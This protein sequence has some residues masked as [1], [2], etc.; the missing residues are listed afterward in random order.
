MTI[1]IQAVWKPSA[2]DMRLWGRPLWWTVGPSGDLA[3]MFVSQRHL[4]QL[5]YIAGWLAWV[6]EAPFDGVLVIRHGGGPVHQRTIKDIPLAP[7]HIA[8]LS[9]GRILIAQ[10]RARKAA[11]ASCGYVRATSGSLRKRRQPPQHH[12]SGPV[13]ANVDV[14]RGSLR[15]LAWSPDGGRSHSCRGAEPLA[16]VACPPAAFTLMN[17]E[18]GWRATD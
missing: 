8:L 10:G 17:D 9:D 6:P 16:V 3:V 15:V 5:S 7:S 1:A 14:P 4:R 11:T 2:A 12:P 13:R 18:V